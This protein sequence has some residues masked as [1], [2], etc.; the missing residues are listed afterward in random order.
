MKSVVETCSESV[1]LQSSEEDERVKKH[2]TSYPYN[3]DVSNDLLTCVMEACAP[4]TGWTTKSP[5]EMAYGL[6][7]E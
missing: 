5:K 7:Y 1:F 4:M 3:I 2:T 6:L